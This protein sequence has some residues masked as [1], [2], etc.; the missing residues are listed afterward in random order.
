HIE[1]ERVVRLKVD[2]L[3]PMRVE[4]LLAV[5]LDKAPDQLHESRVGARLDLS[6][7]TAE[8]LRQLMRSQRQPCHDAERSAAAT[9]QGP[10][11]VVLHALVD[12]SHTAVG[13]DDFRFEQSC[14]RSSEALRVRTESSTEDEAGNAYCHAAAALHV[15]AAPR[16]DRI[17]EIYPH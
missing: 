6:T 9:F 11:E 17:I 14:C 3:T 4:E 1:L 2:G 12:H 8:I 15:A 16:H 13:G 5:E 7:G 10:E